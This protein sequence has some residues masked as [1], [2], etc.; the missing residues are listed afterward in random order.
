MGFVNG[1]GFSGSLKGG[2]RFVVVPGVVFSFVG[3]FWSSSILRSVFWC[4]FMFR[5][6]FWGSFEFSSISWLIS[7]LARVIGMVLG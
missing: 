2:F 7:T 6:V 5:P 4:G 3:G 1:F